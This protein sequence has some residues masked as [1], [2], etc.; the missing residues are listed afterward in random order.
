MVSTEDYR[1]LEEEVSTA[2]STDTVVCSHLYEPPYQTSYF[3]ASKQIKFLQVNDKGT[4]ILGTEWP[5]CK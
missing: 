2:V 3:T 5:M 1:A 4:Y